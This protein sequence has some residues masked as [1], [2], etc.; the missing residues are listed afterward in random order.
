MNRTRRIGRGTGQ[1]HGRFN[2]GTDI[3]RLK[4]KWFNSTISSVRNNWLRIQILWPESLLIPHFK[5]PHVFKI[6]FS[7]INHALY[8]KTIFRLRIL[9]KFKW[10]KLIGLCG[11]AFKLSWNCILNGPFHSISEI[12]FEVFNIVFK[13]IGWGG[14]REIKNE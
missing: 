1:E 4:C 13:R 6:G 12:L 3:R 5:V 9:K 11:Q 7:K 8:K 14:W 2:R 10:N